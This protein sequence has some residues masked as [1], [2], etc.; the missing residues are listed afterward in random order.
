MLNEFE[1]LASGQQVKR[2]CEQEFGQI[3]QQYNLRQLEIEIL[4]F[5]SVSRSMDTARDIVNRRYF[6]KANVSKSVE[7]LR[8]MGYLELL[9]D[10]A[11]RR[12]VHLSVT[13]S[14]MEVVAHIR[15][16]KKHV[17]AVVYDGVTEEEKTV[18]LRV[19]KKIA[20]NIAR[21][22]KCCKEKNRFA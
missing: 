20:D 10:H 19:S 16:I 6:S 3:M 18:L 2:L 11:D 14:G 1:I 21:E 7:H 5:L 4:H 12:R 17:A 8:Q 15:E 13:E 9:H 22:I